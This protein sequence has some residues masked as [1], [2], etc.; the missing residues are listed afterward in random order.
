MREKG[1][2]I[3]GG[4]PVGLG[5][6]VELGQAGVPT[7]VV[8]RN[9]VPPPIPKGQNLTQRTLEHFHFWKA[10]EALRDAQTIPESYGI[11]GITAYGTLLGGLHYDWLQRDRVAQFY[12]RPNGRLP[13]YETERVLRERVAE[14]PSV[15]LLTGLTA[16]DVEQ[17]ER[18]VRVS[19]LASET[20]AVQTLD[21]DF[22]VG[23]DGSH[24]RLRSAAGITQ[25]LDDHGRTMALVLFR[26]EELHEL[27]A[28]FPGKSFYN[29]L[30]PALDGYWKFFGRVDLE[31]RF[32]FHAP[33]PPEARSGDFDF[34]S[35]L[36]SAIGAPC[37]I[38][39][40][41]SGFWDLRFALAD[42]YRNKRLFIAGD[43]AHSHPPYGGFGVNSGLEDARNL[44]WKLA[45]HYA[46]WA[47]DDLLDSY[48][49]ERRP[50]FQS[51]AQD[52]IAALIERDRQFL[53][54]FGPDRDPDSFARNWIG[55]AKG[56]KQEVDQFEPHYGASP[57]IAGPPGQQSS[58]MGQHREEARAGHHLTP[59]N[60]ASGRNSYSLLAPGFTLFS[61]DREYARLWLTSAKA[62]GVPLEAVIGGSSNYG[63][64]HILVRPDQFI[65]WCGDDSP[66]P[67]SVLRQVI[68]ART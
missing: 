49:A 5:L 53:R 28:R 56:A 3:V 25:T 60:L 52:F 65:A 34:V 35:L 8:E 41:Y 12:Y 62:R 10:E 7:R 68:G 44:G 58:A 29:V 27:L 47:G 14:L 43:A 23:C 48:E 45:A 24:S 6:A 63:K 21:G 59:Q 16:Q 39:V 9:H 51:T 26:S 37:A 55:R 1:V 19:V 2:I 38:E 15:T 36:Q 57:I 33:V 66:A 42:T 22:A 40:E 54:D 46:G 61:Q 4:G 64:A 13:Q 17:D 67:D 32:F 31:G 11:S 20:G 30:D 50:V 18:G